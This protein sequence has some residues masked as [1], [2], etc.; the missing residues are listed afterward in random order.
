MSDKNKLAQDRTDWAE[1]RTRLAAERT[2]AGWVRTGLTTVVVALALQAV[3]SVY[4]P[5]WVPKAIASAFLL[6]ALV[7]FVAGWDE[8]RRACR[9]LDTHDA[10]A[11]PTWRL[12]ILSLLLA[13]GTVGIGVVLWQ[14]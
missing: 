8:A 3:F 13:F 10:T 12:S 6:A 4:E 9:D 7:I 14:L 1:D 2:Y 5:K 11:Q